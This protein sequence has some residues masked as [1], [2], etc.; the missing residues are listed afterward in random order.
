VSGR[1][2]KREGEWLKLIEWVRMN[3]KRVCARGGCVRV[4]G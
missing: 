4:R 2:R 1:V 3:G